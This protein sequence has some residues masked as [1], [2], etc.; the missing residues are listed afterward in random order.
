VSA[1]N[2]EVLELCMRDPKQRDADRLA[3]ER[4]ELM[5]RSVRD[6]LDR[7]GVKLHLKEWQGLSLAERERLRDLPC[8][9]ADEVAAYAA[10]LDRLVVRLMGR[11]AERLPGKAD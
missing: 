4:L 7:I 3:E 10:Q 1:K 2:G 11:P 6:K 8:A 5:P 9:T